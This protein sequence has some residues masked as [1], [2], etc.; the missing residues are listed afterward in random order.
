M[1]LQPYVQEE[2]V[3]R[4]K[5]HVLGTSLVISTAEAQGEEFVGDFGFL[6]TPF[7]SVVSAGPI[8]P[9]YQGCAPLAP[10]VMLTFSYQNIMHPSM[11]NAVPYEKLPKKFQTFKC[12]LILLLPTAYQPCIY[13]LNMQPDDCCAIADSIII[14]YQRS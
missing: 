8:L 5:R 13:N 3:M 7:C 6:F 14:S 2:E 10:F 11:S 4:Y 1:I 12:L 9:L